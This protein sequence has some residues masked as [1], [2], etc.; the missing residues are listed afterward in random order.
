MPASKAKG[1]RQQAGGAASPP[2]KKAKGGYCRR[3]LSLPLSLSLSLSVKANVW[4]TG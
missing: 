4:H 3:C 1:K 2:A